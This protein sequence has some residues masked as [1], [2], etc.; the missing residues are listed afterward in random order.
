VTLILFYAFI[1]S[2]NSWTTKDIERD[3]DD[4][5]ILINFNWW[6]DKNCSAECAGSLKSLRDTVLHDHLKMEIKRLEEEEQSFKLASPRAAM[7]MKC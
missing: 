3:E 6:R 7:Y 4:F 5:I 1:C 2:P